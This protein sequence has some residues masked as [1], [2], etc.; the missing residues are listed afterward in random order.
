MR[1]PQIG[2]LGSFGV[3]RKIKKTVDEPKEP[4]PIKNDCITFSAKS[5]YIK[6]YATLPEE[7]KEILTPKDA[8]DMFQNMDFI[9]QGRIKGDLIG[10]GDS[11]RVYENPWLD[12]YDLLIINNPSNQDQIIYSKNILGNS[13]WQDRDN[14]NVQIIKNKAVS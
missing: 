6:K 3:H 11:T 4:L 12:G 7:I 2:Y 13:V 1:V 8:V 10:Y 14:S 9:V 5:K